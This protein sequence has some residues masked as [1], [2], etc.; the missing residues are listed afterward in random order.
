MLEF[1]ATLCTK[2]TLAQGGLFVIHR[3]HRQVYLFMLVLWAC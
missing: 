1:S 3:H 2:K